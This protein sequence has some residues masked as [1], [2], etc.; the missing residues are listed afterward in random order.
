[1]AK[2]IPIDTLT[3]ETSYPLTPSMIKTLRLACEMQS[4]N[5][6]LSQAAL[7]GSFIVLVKRGLID[8]KQNVLKE[9]DKV[10]WY[11]TKLGMRAL[12]DVDAILAC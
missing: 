5:E 11:V 7:S 6:H 12:Q 4:N 3:K 1:M 8:C 2:I 9:E 10:F